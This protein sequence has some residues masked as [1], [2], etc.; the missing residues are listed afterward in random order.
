MEEIK[1]LLL[2][3]EGIITVAQIEPSHRK[4]I[5][6]LESNYEKGGVINLQNP[7]IRM[8]VQCD[9][10][11]AILKDSGFRPPPE[12]TV[13][14]VEDC[15]VD[16][17][18]NDYLITINNKKYNIIGEELINKKPPIDEEYMFIS[19]N[20]ILYPERRKGRAKKPAFFL[21]PPLKFSELEEVKNIYNIKNIISVSPSTISDDYIRKQ[22]NFS[23]RNDYATILIGFDKTT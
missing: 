6:E 8:V 18:E 22:N 5:I 20:F 4:K 10:V 1:K 14:M 23:L 13:L 9:I 16:D 7:G 12:A 21:V 17:L 2:E 3:L 19:D 15:N 11:I